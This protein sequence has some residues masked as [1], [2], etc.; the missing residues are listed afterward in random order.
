M[1]KT[2]QMLFDEHAVISNAVDAAKN[3]KSYLGK[4][5][6]GYERTVRDLLTFFK[7]YGDNFHHQKE[8]EILFPEMK[9]KNELLADGILKE[10]TD[11]HEEFR[12]KLKNIEK[13]LDDKNYSSANQELESYCEALLDHIA[14]ENDEVFQIAETI[15]SENELEN[16]FGRFEDCDIVTGILEKQ[17]LAEMADEI[18]K[19]LHYAD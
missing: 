12:E 4:N 8:E 19:N 7:N 10:M 14:V 2:I 13:Y 17:E 9:K 1:N 15:L 16:I 11:N 18:R 6:M 3:A 5:D